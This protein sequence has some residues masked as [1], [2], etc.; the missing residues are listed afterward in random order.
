MEWLSVRGASV[1]P[2]GRP[3]LCS[4]P[5]TGAGTSTT[6]ASVA[7]MGHTAVPLA[8]ISTSARRTN[9]SAPRAPS[10]GPRPQPREKWHPWR[11]RCLCE[12]MLLGLGLARRGGLG[13]EKQH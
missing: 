4:T 9:D 7:R 2:I 12:R 8:R 1:P 11:R 3:T 6:P 13:E 10:V 5:D